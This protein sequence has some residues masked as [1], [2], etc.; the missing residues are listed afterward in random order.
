[1]NA[2]RYPRRR[3]QRLVWLTLLSW[4]FALASGVVNACVLNL[5]GRTADGPG[6]LART[7]VATHGSSTQGIGTHGAEEHAPASHAVE[8]TRGKSGETTCLKFCADESSAV[9]KSAATGVDMAPALVDSRVERRMAVLPEQVES[10]FAPER[11][12]AQGPPLVIRF[13]RLTL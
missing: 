1:M 3:L 8:Q 7:A 13:L 10:G 6:L 9:A 12:H 5:P 2:F 4:S 11:S